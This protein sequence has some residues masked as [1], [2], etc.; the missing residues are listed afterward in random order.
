MEI[1]RALCLM[2]L[3][4]I[5]HRLGISLLTSEVDLHGENRVFSIH[6]KK[7]IGA[8]ESKKRARGKREKN[9]GKG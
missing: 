8:S 2:K 7:G 9:K 5:I 6:V 1:V 3:N 4:H